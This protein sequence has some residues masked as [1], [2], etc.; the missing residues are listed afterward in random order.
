V[1]AGKSITEAV[2]KRSHLQKT[3]A[4][5]EMVQDNTQ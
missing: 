2:E 5:K 3:R 4:I 1:K